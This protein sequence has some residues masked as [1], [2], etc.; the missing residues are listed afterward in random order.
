MPDE[1]QESY[2]LRN[3]D[4][5][6]EYECVSK[7]KSNAPEQIEKKSCLKKPF[8]VRWQLVV[9][10]IFILFAV[11]VLLLLFIRATRNYPLRELRRRRDFPSFASYRKI[12]GQDLSA[13]LAVWRHSVL[14]SAADGGCRR[15]YR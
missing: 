1:R 15:I 6:R 11:D 12:L 3:M 5:M 2:R 8:P 10:D 14:Y 7:E 9:Y 4:K 13:D